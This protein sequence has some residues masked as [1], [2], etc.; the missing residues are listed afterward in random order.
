MIARA[1]RNG[2]IVV[3]LA[4]VSY[5]VKKIDGPVA[6]RRSRL[7]SFIIDVVLV[8]APNVSFPR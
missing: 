2:S 6:Y 4:I 5:R 1:E 7:P 8:L 3:V